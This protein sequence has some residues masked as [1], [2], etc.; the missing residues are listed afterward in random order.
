MRSRG[1]TLI[2]RFRAS[3]TGFSSC[4]RARLPPSP[5]RGPAPGPGSVTPQDTPTKKEG[6]ESEALIL[7]SDSDEAVSPS[8]HKKDDNDGDDSSSDE[9][10]E[11]ESGEDES[12]EDDSGE[13]SGDEDS[14]DEDHSDEEESDEE[15]SDEEESDEE[16]SDE[17]D[18]SD[19]TSTP[20]SKRKIPLAT[21]AQ[22]A[23]PAFMPS[24]SQ[25]TFGRVYVRCHSP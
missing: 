5:Q 22:N 21:T 12:S 24:E 17:E 11:D 13:E 7:N 4:C 14:D 10:G 15:E 19:E 16:E 8:V 1:A 3:S 23:P 18:S 2:Q 25:S 6:P 9:S 20:P